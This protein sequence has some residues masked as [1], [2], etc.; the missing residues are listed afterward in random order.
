MHFWSFFFLSL[1]GE[2][3]VPLGGFTNPRKRNQDVTLE[4]T[5]DGKVTQVP[6]SPD[7]GSLS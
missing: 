2:A 1:L 3:A 6:L 4:L 7:I 5:E